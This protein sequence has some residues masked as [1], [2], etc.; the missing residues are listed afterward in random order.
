MDGVGLD[1]RNEDVNRRRTRALDR[2]KW[3]SVIRDTRSK[4]KGL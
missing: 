2:I 3:T 4:F 1:L